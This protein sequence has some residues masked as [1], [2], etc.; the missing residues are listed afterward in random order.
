MLAANAARS[1]R[2]DY[3]EWPAP[4]GFDGLEAEFT[5]AP[6]YPS[7]AGVGILVLSHSANFASS[8]TTSPSLPLKVRP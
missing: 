4:G 7:T 2:V 5:L 8:I 6:Q 3:A 1:A